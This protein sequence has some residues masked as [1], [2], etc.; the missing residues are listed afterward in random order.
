MTN[1]DIML[2]LDTIKY[3]QGPE[4]DTIRQCLTQALQPVVAN[5]AITECMKAMTDNLIYGQSLVHTDKDGNIK[6]IPINDINHPDWKA[7]A[8]ELDNS[9]SEARNI[10]Q[11]WACEYT[12]KEEVKDGCECNYCKFQRVQDKYKSVMGE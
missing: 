4:Y 11:I 12:D 8:E 5:N 1:E 10:I 7:V 3:E 2:A 9:L 6:H